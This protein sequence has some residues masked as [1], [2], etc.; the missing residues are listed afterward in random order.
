MRARLFNRLAARIGV[1]QR[2]KLAVNLVCQRGER[3]E[4]ANCRS[5]R[6]AGRAHRIDNACDLAGIARD[7]RVNLAAH[8]F[9]H[10]CGLDRRRLD[11]IFKQDLTPRPAFRLSK[12]LMVLKERNVFRRNQ[13]VERL[14]C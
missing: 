11:V 3:I 1:A 8:H 14:H 4:Q 6:R 7:S 5:G 10:G 12:H 13:A 2:V 9:N